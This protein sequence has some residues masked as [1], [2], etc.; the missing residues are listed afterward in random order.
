MPDSLLQGADSPAMAHGM[1]ARARL[2]SLVPFRQWLGTCV[3]VLRV[4]GL[5]GL[6]PGGQLITEQIVQLGV[7]L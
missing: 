1:P 4:A 5:C 7:P 6:Q 3:R 2:P